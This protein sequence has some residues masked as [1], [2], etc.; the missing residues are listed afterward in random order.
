MAPRR[1]RRRNQRRGRSSRKTI[2]CPFVTNLVQNGSKSID[3]DDLGIS[4]FLN[5]PIKPVSAWFQCSCNVPTQFNVPVVTFQLWNQF[6]KPSCTSRPVQALLTPSPR[7]HVSA[8]RSDDFQITDNAGSIV[9]ALQLTNL[10]STEAVIVTITGIV[11][12]AFKSKITPTPVSLSLRN[13]CPAPPSE[14]PLHNK[15]DSPASPTVDL[16]FDKL[17]L[18]E[19]GNP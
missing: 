1:T 16:S 15:S 14:N 17:T 18:E 8:P 19:C 7:T 6:S 3:L 5:I 4:S 12:I 11:R 2:A 13:F 10:S 9:A